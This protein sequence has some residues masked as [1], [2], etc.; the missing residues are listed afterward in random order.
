MC[1]GKLG[2]AVPKDLDIPYTAS[3][4]S[5]LLLTI[6]RKSNESW[7]DSLVQPRESKQALPPVV[8]SWCIHCKENRRLKDGRASYEDRSPRWVLGTPSKYVERR[9]KCLTC[10]VKGRS[11]TGRFIPINASIPSIYGRKLWI[12]DRRW[13]SLRDGVSKSRNSRL[14]AEGDKKAKTSKGKPAA[15]QK[16]MRLA[17]LNSTA[18]QQ[19]SIDSRLHSIVS[20]SRLHCLA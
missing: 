12:F 13:A 17:P 7:R 8:V 10:Q 4:Q 11:G 2:F 1:Q 3:D 16:K 15:V 14:R 19:T 6:A 9:P 20:Q 5:S 18:I